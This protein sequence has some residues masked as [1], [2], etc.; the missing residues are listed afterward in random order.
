MFCEEDNAAIIIIVVC[1]SIPFYSYVDYS[2]PSYIEN[3]CFVQFHQIAPHKSFTRVAVTG[4]L[5]V[6]PMLILL[7]FYWYLSYRRAL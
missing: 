6:A 4:C 1:V 5:L 7:G 2:T 3:S